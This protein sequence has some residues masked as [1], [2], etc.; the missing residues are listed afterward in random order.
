MEAA[1]ARPVASG[2]ASHACT[3]DRA[4]RIVSVLK[5]VFRRMSPAGRRARLSILIFHRVLGSHDPLLPDVPDAAAFDRILGWI[6]SWFNLL[7]LDRAVRNARERCAAG[8]RSR[9]NV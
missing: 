1:G 5:H 2:G 3:H 7:P 9:D 8:A 6:S 4:H